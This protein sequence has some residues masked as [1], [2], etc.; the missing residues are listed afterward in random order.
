M[1]SHAPA[2]LLRRARIRGLA[3]VALL[4]LVVGNLTAFW[5]EATVLHM[6]CAEHGEQIHVAAADPSVTATDVAERMVG[7]AD[8]SL[9]RT[10]VGR[11]AESGHEHCSLCPGTRDGAAPARTI[12]ASATL[13]ARP[14][15]LSAP[16]DAPAPA[17]AVH[18][19]APKHGPPVSA[20]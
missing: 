6:V 13:V 2:H 19:L 17:I 20:G 10:A 9:H 5:H 14:A 15:L 4:A 1:V 12:I 11:D 8:A 7:A 3:V 16:A 18:R